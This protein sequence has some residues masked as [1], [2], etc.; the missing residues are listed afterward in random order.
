MS[1]KIGEMRMK[2]VVGVIHRRGRTCV[3]VRVGTT[4][5]K[6]WIPFEGVAADEAVLRGWIRGM[7]SARQSG[8]ASVTIVVNR[9]LLGGQ[10]RLGWKVRSLS[11]LKAWREFSHAAADLPVNFRYPGEIH[12][13]RSPS[14]SVVGGP[15]SKTSEDTC[16][17]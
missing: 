5:Y 3:G 13:F 17:P 8:A 14:S 6:E 4:V 15:R 11:L 10:L 9:A 2:A 1:Q 16:P 7:E 12:S